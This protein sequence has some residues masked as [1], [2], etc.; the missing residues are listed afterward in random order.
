MMM[1]MERSETQSLG[2]A[3]SNEP[4]HQPLMTKMMKNEYR[5]TGMMINGGKT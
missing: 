1:V 5:G 2:T 3:G 4:L